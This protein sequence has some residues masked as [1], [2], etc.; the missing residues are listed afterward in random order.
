MNAQRSGD[1]MKSLVQYSVDIPTK[2]NFA[3]KENL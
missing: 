1:C 2:R 3:K